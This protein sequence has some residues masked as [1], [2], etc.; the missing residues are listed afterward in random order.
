MLNGLGVQAFLGFAGLVCQLYWFAGFWNVYYVLKALTHLARSKAD[1]SEKLEDAST[2]PRTTSSG[3][4]TTCSSNGSMH[5]KRKE[6]WNRDVI[7]GGAITAH[8]AWM[9]STQESLEKTHEDI[10]AALGKGH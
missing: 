3:A 10:T 5:K 2:P 1:G 6:W 7:I 8:K 9:S 4:S